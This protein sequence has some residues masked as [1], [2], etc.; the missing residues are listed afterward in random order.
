MTNQVPILSADD[1]A[2]AERE[3]RLGFPP[4]V[5]RAYRKQMIK[6]QGRSVIA[7][8]LIGVGLYDL[9]LA[10]DYLVAPDDILLYA[11][12]RLGCVTP[13]CVLALAAG[14]RFRSIYEYAICVPPLIM[15]AVLSI[16]IMNTHGSYRT[17]YLFGDIL[18]M[19]CGTV[20]SRSR[21]RFTLGTVVLQ[22]ACFAFTLF[23][24]DAVPANSL[25]VGMLFCTSGA[26][27]AL[28]TAF[29]LEQAS[30]MAF[31]MSTRI[32]MLNRELEAAATTD[33]LTGLA[34]RRGARPSDGPAVDN[35]WRPGRDDQSDPDRCRP[36]QVVQRQL[37]PRRR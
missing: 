3:S 5:E 11:L 21:F 23:H 18:L 2:K 4:V 22:F 27:L 12:G 30:R 15:S 10:N 28:L 17:Y 6:G 24:T 29:A 20:I 26:V 37:R 25:L 33:P 8:W 32:G 7:H 36:V 9:F 19:M 13:V 14:F 1:L 35:Q 31:L 16:L 34:N